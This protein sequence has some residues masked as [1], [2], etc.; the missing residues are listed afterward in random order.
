MSLTPVQVCIHNK[1]KSDA[2]VNGY[3]HTVLRATNGDLKYIIFT[4][5]E[6]SGSW[7]PSE[8]P[9]YN[10]RLRCIPLFDGEQK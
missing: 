1:M 10:V 8:F 2:W 5:E 7:T 3:L 9:A 4:R 6:P